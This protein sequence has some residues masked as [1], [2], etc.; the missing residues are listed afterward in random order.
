MSEKQKI[1]YNLYLFIHNLMWNMID[2][3]ITDID[4]KS[5]LGALFDVLGYIIREM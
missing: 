4:V 5:E 2:T 1:K 3:A